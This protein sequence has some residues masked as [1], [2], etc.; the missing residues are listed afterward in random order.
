MEE[1]MTKKERV[2]QAIFNAVDEINQ[3]FPKEDRLEKSI[4][5]VLFGQSAKLD[6]LGLVNLI[7]TT[8][9]KIEEEF[10][11]T[12]TLANE[13]AMSQKN[14]PFRTIETLAGYIFLLLEE[15]ANG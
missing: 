6:S 5:A 3:Q 12:I 13:K 1:Q 2:I 8:E 10:D 15:S 9:Q 7:V 4:D 11:T 14:S